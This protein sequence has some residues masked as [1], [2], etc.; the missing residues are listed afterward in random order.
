VLH[1]FRDTLSV[2]NAH[3][4]PDAPLAD[5]AV[6]GGVLLDRRLQP[7][8]VL[9]G[10]RGQVLRLSNGCGRSE[11]RGGC[12]GALTTGV[13]NIRVVRVIHPAILLPPSGSQMPS[14]V[15]VYL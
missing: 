15:G 12:P 6:R 8:T 2:S 13:T 14:G 3:G 11:T 1:R 9:V 10:V 5:G 4:K 7:R